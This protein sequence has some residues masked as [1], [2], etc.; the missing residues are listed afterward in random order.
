MKEKKHTEKINR[1]RHSDRRAF[2]LKSM[3]GGARS[4][5]SWTVSI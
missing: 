3:S 2:L 1:R 4:P 5:M